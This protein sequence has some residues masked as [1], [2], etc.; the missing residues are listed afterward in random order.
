MHTEHCEE[1]FGK[2]GARIKFRPA[3]RWETAALTPVIDIKND[4]RGEFFDVAIPKGIDS[5]IR[6]LD[7]QP[8]SK[9]LLLM[10]SSDQSSAKSK[11]LCGHDEMHWFV[12]QVPDNTI[13]VRDAIEKLKPSVVQEA[14]K[15]AKKKNRNR[16]KNA[17]FVRQGEWFFLRRPGFEP[18]K[19]A[20]IFRN[21]PLKRGAGSKPHMVEEL[22][23]PKG[24]T[25]MVHR[26]FATAG[27]SMKEFT[28]LPKE[29]RQDR[30]WRTMSRTA[31]VYVRGKVRHPDHSTI[32]LP[33]WH[34]VVLSLENNSAVVG[35]LD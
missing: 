24:E 15:G 13:N 19:D 27:I 28:E 18:P 21:E 3:K 33:F 16:R 9:H 25:V 17:A 7:V 6:V 11:V 4:K 14:S 1:K 20:I 22:Y 30:G 12:A 10:V 34:E 31:S 26:S 23:R 35:F 32:E 2:V 5:D 29:R 8:K